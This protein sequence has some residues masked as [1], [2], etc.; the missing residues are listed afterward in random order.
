MVTLRSA[1]KQPQPPPKVNTEIVEILSSDSENEVD[2]DD[3]EALDVEPPSSVTLADPSPLFATPGV[4]YGEDKFQRK[5]AGEVQEGEEEAAEGSEG[6]EERPQDEQESPSSA[7]LAV[8]PKGARSPKKGRV[9]VEIPVPK[10]ASKTQRKQ[11]GD[12]KK[13]SETPK[14][15]KHITFDD[16]E[17]D[18]FVTPKEA[19]T[20]DP[21]ENQGVEEDEEEEEEEDSDDEAPEAVSTRTAEVETLKAAG[22]AA[23]AA[24]QQAAAAK[25]KRQERDTFLKKQAEERKRLQKPAV[26]Q[27]EDDDDDVP[28]TTKALA[29]EGEK[30]KREVPQLLP[31]ELLESDDEED[32]PRQT[33][34][35]ADQQNK[36]RKLGSAELALLNGPRLPKDKRVGTTAYRVVKGTGDGRL[37]P[38]ARKQSVNLKE[39]LLRRDRV[40]K[41]RGGFFVKSR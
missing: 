24:E 18:E 6:E 4:R 9:S 36:R 8:R 15:G 29:T 40:A 20:E 5:E 13:S 23:K 30:R 1:G 33:D 10:S 2:G 37:A 14:A 28:T 26:Q 11:D 31:L 21:L 17:Y 41:P 34:S 39:M 22:A 16:S 3:D 27:D 38:K 7:K 19:P 25:Q 12:S 32:T 35:A